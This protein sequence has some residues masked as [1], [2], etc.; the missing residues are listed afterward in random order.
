MTMTRYPMRK[1]IIGWSGCAV[2][3]ERAAGRVDGCAATLDRWCGSYVLA[4]RWSRTVPHLFFAPRT[5]LSGFG[6]NRPRRED[7]TIYS[8]YLPSLDALAE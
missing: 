7:G 2:Y 6:A 1:K 5:E 3:V 8:Y 4:I